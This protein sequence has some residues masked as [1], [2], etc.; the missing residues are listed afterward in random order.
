MRVSS[1]P[2]TGL[3]NLTLLATIVG[4]SCAM[5]APASASIVWTLTG[6]L[7]DGG[8]VGTGSYFSWT[9]RLLG[10]HKW[11]SLYNDHEWQFVAWLYVRRFWI[12][13]RRRCAAIRLR[14]YKR[15]L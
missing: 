2:L 15:L 14:Y 11:Q 4:A 8:T 12:V 9:N 10:F 6:T 5:S 13:S 1:L 3:R 7:D